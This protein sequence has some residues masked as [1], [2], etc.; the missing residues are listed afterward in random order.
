MPCASTLVSGVV[1]KSSERYEPVNDP[2]RIHLL[3]LYFD[4][5]IITSKYFDVI[6]PESKYKNKR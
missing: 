4:S 1:A 6:I 5:G 2:V 3:F